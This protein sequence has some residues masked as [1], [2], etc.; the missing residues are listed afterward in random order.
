MSKYST[1]ELQRMAN[2]VLRYR[3]SGA[4][5]N[6]E[7]YLSFMVTLSMAT[8]LNMAELEARVER[9]NRGEAV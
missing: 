4:Q 2:T 7:T 6:Q 1:D 9:L 5:A 3:C 8:G